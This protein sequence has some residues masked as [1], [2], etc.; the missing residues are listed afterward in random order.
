[1]KTMT[2]I[3]H[4][5]FAAIIMAMGAVTSNAALGDLF[6][7]INGDGSNGGVQFT[8]THRLDSKPSSLQAF[9]SRAGWRLTISAT[10]LWQIRRSM[11]LPKRFRQ[12]L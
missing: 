5:A 8:N 10:C 1:M 4:I 12:R 3:I 6:A 7:S 9:R 11:T 2:K